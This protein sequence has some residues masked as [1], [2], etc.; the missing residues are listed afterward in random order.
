MSDQTPPPPPSSSNTNPNTTSPRNT[1]TNNNDTQNTTPSLPSRIQSSAS[2][3]ARN[4]FFNSTPPGDIAN[5]LPGGS[6]AGPASATGARGGTAHYHTEASIP[7]GSSSSSSARGIAGENGTGGSFRS[8]STAQSQD[9][10]EAFQR[11]YQD[12]GGDLGFLDNQQHLQEDL[13]IG[14]PYTAHDTG[15][16]KE[17]ATEPD[18]PSPSTFDDI[19]Q[20]T[21]TTTSSIPQTQLPHPQ[22]QNQ[23]QDGAEVLTLLSSPSFNPDFPPSLDE[24]NNNPDA[25]LI[26]TDLS[27][28]PPPLPHTQDETLTQTEMQVL[29]SF[30][31]QDPHPHQQQG[32]RR[33][34]NSTSLVPDIGAFLDTT[35]QQN[36]KVDADATSLRDAVL[37]GLP[38][39]EDWVAVEEMYQDEVWGYLKPALQA[40]A[41]EMEEQQQNQSQGGSTGED[42]PAVARLKMILRHMG[43]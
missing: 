7:P 1:N 18:A 17:K 37:T 39:A 21:T 10:E 8:G 30:R 4:A 33:N 38:G 9:D 16:G 42:G 13:G 2:N 6:K 3:L 28:Q 25:T 31:R 26:P 5:A 22:L 36:N 32:Q 23:H 11:G 43:A 19:W 20:T 24:L 27:D 14:H 35:P 41:K 40:A 15:K 12:D 34:L 29:D